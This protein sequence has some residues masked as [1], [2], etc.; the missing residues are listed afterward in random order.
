MEYLVT[1]SIPLA[2]AFL[3]FVQGLAPSIS[4]YAHIEEIEIPDIKGGPLKDILETNFDTSTLRDFLRIALC[5]T[6][7]LRVL[8]MLPFP[9]YVFAILLSI[10]K[11]AFKVSLNI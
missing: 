8:G 2:H 1:L 11:N 3:A 4:Q 5:I 9:L 10:T 6:R 7:G